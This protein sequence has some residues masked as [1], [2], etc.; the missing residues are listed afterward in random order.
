MANQI[1]RYETILV[2]NVALGEEAVSGLCEKFK[3]LIAENA[4]VEKIEEWG[5]RKLAYPIEDETEGYYLL[6]HYESKPDFPAELNRVLEITE[7][8]LRH[9]IVRNEVEQQPA[10]PTAAQPAPAAQEAETPAPQA[11]PTAEE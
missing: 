7:G 5:K 11:V 8:V 10:K 2:F 4:T 6:F 1:M 3:T 9:L